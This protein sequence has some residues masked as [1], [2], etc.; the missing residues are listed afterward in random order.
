MYDTA[1]LVRLCMLQVYLARNQRMVLNPCQLS[2]PNPKCYVCSEKPEVTLQV[3]PSSLSLQTLRDKVHLRLILRLSL[4]SY[5]N[6]SVSPVRLHSRAE[7]DISVSLV[8]T[9]LTLLHSDRR[10]YIMYHCTV[11][12]RY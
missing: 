4:T 2:K 10:F 8:L 1:V 5:T 9:V 6:D 11:P 7:T 3:N 12:C